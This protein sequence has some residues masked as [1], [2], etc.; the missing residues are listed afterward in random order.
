MENTTVTFQCNATGHPTPKITWTKDEKILGEGN[1]LI[2][3]AYRNQSGE[4]KCTAD[5]GRNSTI[6]ASASLD[7]QCELRNI[8]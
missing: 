6:N 7:V 5:S 1:T 2:F 8:Y 3:V 4:Y